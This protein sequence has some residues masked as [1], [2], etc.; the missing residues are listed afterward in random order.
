MAWSSLLQRGGQICDRGICQTYLSYKTSYSQYGQQWSS[1]NCDSSSQVDRS[2]SVC[3]HR[4][5][6]TDRLSQHDRNTQA[7]ISVQGAFVIH[8]TA[9]EVELPV[10][11]NEL[12]RVVGLGVSHLIFGDVQDTHDREPVVS[13]AG[14]SI[15]YNWRWWEKRPS[16]FIDQRE[17][18]FTSE[19]RREKMLRGV[20]CQIYCK[21]R[22]VLLDLS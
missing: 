16:S 7:W 19:I 8:V 10:V 12:Q 20:Q 14:M 5:R 13:Q 18:F 4:F 15:N 9:H 1:C 22:M 2:N 17:F 21:R 11:P 3:G 6:I